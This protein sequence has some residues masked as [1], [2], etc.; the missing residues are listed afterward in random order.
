MGVGEYGEEEMLAKLNE[1]VKMGSRRPGYPAVP[2]LHYI[3]VVAQGLA[4]KDGSIVSVCLILRI[5]SAK[6]GKINAIIF[7][8]FR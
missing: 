2:A 6:D 5:D 1:E 7:W 8:I 4:G 3:A